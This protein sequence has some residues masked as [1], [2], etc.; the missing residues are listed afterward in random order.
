M[1]VNFGTLLLVAF[2]LI[3]ISSGAIVLFGLLT[4]GLLEKWA[5]LFLRSS[6]AASVTG[7]LFSFHPFQPFT[8]TQGIFALSVYVVGGATVAWRKY[9]LAGVWCSVF[10]LTATIVLY[11]NV[12][13]AITQAF[14]QV[15]PFMA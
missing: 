14:K 12:A 5:V 11:L 1:I 3:A 4:G 13:V 10:A 9:R 15:S 8:H 2:R 6:L 7:L